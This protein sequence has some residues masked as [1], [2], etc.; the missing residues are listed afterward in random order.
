MAPCDQKEQDHEQANCQSTSSSQGDDCVDRMRSCRPGPL[1]GQRPPPPGEMGALAPRAEDDLDGRWWLAFYDPDT[2]LLEPPQQYPDTFRTAFLTI[3]DNRIRTFTIRSDDMEL[4]TEHDMPVRLD[5][6][7]VSFELT[8]RQIINSFSGESPVETEVEV[9]FEG[10][11]ARG[12]FFAGDE[13]RTYLD[14]A[15]GEPGMQQ[16]IMYRRRPV[17][18][19]FVGACLGVSDRYDCEASGGTWVRDCLFDPCEPVDDV[20]DE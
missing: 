17:Q 10:Q 7:T 5:G 8:T 3:R 15:P 18:C 13:I 2:G 16:S 20:D 4:E 11:R 12:S 9:A 19:C 1:H 6:D 14:L